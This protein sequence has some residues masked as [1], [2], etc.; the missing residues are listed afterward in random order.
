MRQ[1]GRRFD[2]RELLPG[3]VEFRRPGW[4]LRWRRGLTGPLLWLLVGLHD[5]A[6][7]VVARFAVELP[8]DHALEGAR[9][10]RDAY[11]LVVALRVFQ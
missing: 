9:L 8:V 7:L 5:A 1:A 10:P 2:L 3:G 6:G 4:G 11:L